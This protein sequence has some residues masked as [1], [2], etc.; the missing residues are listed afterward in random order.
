MDK[1]VLVHEMTERFQ[2]LY[3]Q[4]L[5]ALENAPDGEWIRNGCEIT[6]RFPYGRVA[7]S[8]RSERAKLAI[9]GQHPSIRVAIQNGKL[10]RLRS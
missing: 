4:A 7:V 9:K 3:A 10:L 6:S 2:E 8:L 1:D 5:A